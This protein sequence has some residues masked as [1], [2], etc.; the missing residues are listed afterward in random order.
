LIRHPI[1]L[2]VNRSTAGE[3]AGLAF[4]EGIAAIRA[5]QQINNVCHVRSFVKVG[6]WGS[7]VAT[8]LMPRPMLDNRP[9]AVAC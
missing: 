4:G 1:V 3:I 7:A 8:G 2:R 5:T 9:Q 6:E